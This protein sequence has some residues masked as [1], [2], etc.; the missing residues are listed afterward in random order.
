[1]PSRIEQVALIYKFNNAF[2]SRALAGLDEANAWQRP[3]GGNP[4]AWLLGHVTHSRQ[5]LLALLGAPWDSGLG[6]AFKRGAPLQGAPS[7]PSVSAIA[8]AWAAT[9]HRMRDAFAAVTDERLLEPAAGVSIP[10]TKTVADVISFLALHESYHVGQMGYVRRAL[11]LPG[12][13]DGS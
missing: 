7:Y 13:A 4:I 6:A 2:V 10:G 11:G 12:V 3:A 9:H 1:M 5:Q 8:A